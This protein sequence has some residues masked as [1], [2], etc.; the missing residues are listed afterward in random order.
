[1]K[2]I[3]TIIL[4]L[5]VFTAKA[6]SNPKEVHSKV[7]EYHAMATEF[8]KTG[9]ADVYKTSP[10]ATEITCMLTLEQAKV[11]MPFFVENNMRARSC[12]AETYP[13]KAVL[14]KLSVDKFKA[15]LDM[16]N[17]K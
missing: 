13:T 7:K 4:L 5:A 8:K 3:S 2:F 10:L 6:Q 12:G 9:K 16:F 17:G 15:A 1:M 11:A 14:N